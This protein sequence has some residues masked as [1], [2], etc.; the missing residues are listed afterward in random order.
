M[1][2]ETTE[3][4]NSFSRSESLKE[5]YGLIWLF[6]PILTLVSGITIGVLVILWLERERSAGIQERIGPEYAGPLGILQAPGPNC[7]SR[8][9]FSERLLYSVSDHL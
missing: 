1:I 7:F 4:K 5:A 3:A 6:V 8:R 2:I 9:I